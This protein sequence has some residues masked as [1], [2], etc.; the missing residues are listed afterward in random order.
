MSEEEKAP[1]VE[2]AAKDKKRYERE[3]KAADTGSDEGEAAKEDDEDE[4]SE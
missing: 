2:E 4:G 3:V 1:F